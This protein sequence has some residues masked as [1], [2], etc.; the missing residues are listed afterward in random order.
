MGVDSVFAKYMVGVDSTLNSF[1]LQ[2]LKLTPVLFP[3]WPKNSP[4]L[5]D[6]VCTGFSLNIRGFWP[7]LG[8][9]KRSPL[10]PTPPTPSQGC[11]YFAWR[12]SLSPPQHEQPKRNDSKHQTWGPLNLMAVTTQSPMKGCCP[13]PDQSR[14]GIGS[15]SGRNRVEIGSISGWEPGPFA[16]SGPEAGPKPGPPKKPFSESGRNR[17]EIGSKSDRN[18]VEIGSKSGRDLILT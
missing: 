12:T 13:K 14:V 7:C 1:R 15:E 17:V 18:R 6:A 3:A 11:C 10:L 8:T 5:P 16:S 9:D 4:P 2:P